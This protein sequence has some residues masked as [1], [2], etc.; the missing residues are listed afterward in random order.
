VCEGEWALKKASVLLT[1]DYAFLR[2]ASDYFN[3]C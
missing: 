3:V 2:K 1:G